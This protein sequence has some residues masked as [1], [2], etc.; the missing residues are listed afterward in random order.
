MYPQL[1]I[2]CSENKTFSSW[3]GE[4]RRTK[5][6]SNKDLGP[7]MCKEAIKSMCDRESHDSLWPF[8][9]YCCI[10]Y[11]YLQLWSSDHNVFISRR[12]KLDVYERPI[13][14]RKGTLYI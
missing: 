13:E 2:L 7:A 6:L 4:R 11:V 14:E 1:T 9:V 10:M 8:T 12:D 3:R 5:D